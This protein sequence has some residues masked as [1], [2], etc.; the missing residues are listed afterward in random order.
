M[1]ETFSPWLPT[2]KTWADERLNNLP[3]AGKYLHAICTTRDVREGG[4][5]PRNEER[6]LGRTSA[7]AYL[8]SANLVESSSPAPK[9]NPHSA[10][11]WTTT[12]PAQ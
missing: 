5:G 9:S 7:L 12:G 6:V 11:S 4:Y 3:A 8:I 10:T 1:S 2:S